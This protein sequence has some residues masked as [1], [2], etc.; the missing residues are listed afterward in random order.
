MNPDDIEKQKSAEQKRLDSHC[1]EMERQAW[2]KELKRLVEGCLTSVEGVEETFEELNELENRRRKAEA[3]IEL[4]LIDKREE[5]FK[6][7]LY[8]VVE[9]TYHRDRFDGSRYKIVKILER[10]TGKIIGRGRV[11]LTKRKRGIKN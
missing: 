3:E 9:E 8:E 10:R 5:E 2:N 6:Q 11:E 4:E 7:E 1:E